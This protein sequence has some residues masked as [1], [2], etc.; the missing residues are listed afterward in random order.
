[1]RTGIETVLA[2]MGIH[3]FRLRGECL[4]GLGLAYAGGQ[5]IIAKSGGFGVPETLVTLAE[6]L[7]GGRG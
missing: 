6:K 7:H 2:A 1:M 4:P 3:S 5:C